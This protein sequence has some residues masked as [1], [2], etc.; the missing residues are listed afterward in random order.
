MASTHKLTMRMMAVQSLWLFTCT[1]CLLQLLSVRFLYTTAFV[2]FSARGRIGKLHWKKTVAGA[3]PSRVRIVKL[4]LQLQ[5]QHESTTNN[6]ARNSNRKS[7]LTEGA[8][9]SIA[10]LN[11]RRACTLGVLGVMTSQV[12]LAQKNGENKAHAASATDSFLM[13]TQKAE[14]SDLE[15]GLLDGRVTENVLSP[16]PYGMEG[17]DIFYPSWFAGTWKVK[18]VG[19]D[20][21][22]PCGIALFG[23]NKTYEAAKNDIGATLKYESRFLATGDDTCIADREY[24]VRS[25][26]K[27]AMGVNSVVD[28]PEASPNKIS[29]ILALEGAPS[30]LKV[31][32]ITLKRRQELEASDRF[33]CSEVS[34]EIVAPI[35]NNNSPSSQQSA[36]VLKEVETTSLYTFD[37]AK[38]EIKCRQ[39]SATFL[40]PSQQNPTAMKMWEAARGRPISVR[41][42]DVLYTKK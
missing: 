19:T 5:I 40:L 14:S 20:V 9:G 41:F 24:N 18:S 2:P 4:Q 26:A 3:E 39:R 33:D 35:G 29:C 22:A 28:I 15:S 7:I 31:D 13:S 25:I 23:G 16:P 27:A 10:S 17:S 37:K 8:D 12:L 36:P 21:Q 11:R 1:A 38:D 42:Y 30:L 34:R 6:A 32:L